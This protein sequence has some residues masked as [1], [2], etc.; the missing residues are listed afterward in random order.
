MLNC[1]MYATEKELPKKRQYDCVIY[2]HGFG[3]D[4]SN[5][6]S[7]SFVSLAKQLL[8]PNYPDAPGQIKKAVFYTK[9]AVHIL[10]NALYDR[11]V[12]KSDKSIVLVGRSC[13]AGI[14]INCL[15]KLI[16]YDAA[17][18]SESNVKSQ[19]EASQIIEAINNGM[20]IATAPFTHL[21]KANLIAISSDI[22]GGV[23]IT[24][25][26]LGMYFYTQ[27]GMSAIA[28]QVAQL[29][30]LNAG[31]LTYCAGAGDLIKS[32]YSR[33]II[34]SIVTR[35]SNNYYD[36][37]HQHPLDVVEG[38]RGRLTC[39]MLLHFNAQD[40]VL[41]NPDDD[42]V[43]IYDALRGDKTHIIITDDSWH[44]GYSLQFT[45]MLYAFKK[46]YID[47]EC[48]DNM[49]GVSLDGLRP[50][51]EELRKKIYSWGFISKMW[52]SKKWA[53]S[54]VVLCMLPLLFNSIKK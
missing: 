1:F 28:T 15:E 50:S 10:A 22:I 49:E 19:E 8:V 29:C 17:Y 11:V 21:K 9:P 27:F 40:G 23:T 42:T 26:M 16:N 37:N 45:K 7:G 53:I 35:I 36:S 30:L 14:A 33:L 34:R 48:E 52:S 12:L 6:D 24:G 32:L 43:K 4:Q 44:N 47:G 20:F 5:N 31:L 18:F 46:K 2:S 54:L 3:E 51:T 25:A 13:G 38:L 41:E 39:P